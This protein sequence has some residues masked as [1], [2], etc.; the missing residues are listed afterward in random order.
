MLLPSQHYG[1]EFNR[2]SLDGTS[3]ARWSA[4]F[5]GLGI[6]VELPDDDL[7]GTLA[8]AE[9]ADRIRADEALLAAFVANMD[10]ELDAFVSRTDGTANSGSLIWVPSSRASRSLA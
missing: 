8:L 10:R 7:Q 4:S 5:D 9:L 2:R 6:P 1:H 3:V